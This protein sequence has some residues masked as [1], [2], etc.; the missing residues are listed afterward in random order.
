[1]QEIENFWIAN[2]AGKKT[3]RIRR[4]MHR[5]EVR[6]QLL[7]AYDQ[8]LIDKIRK[9]RDCR[10]SETMNCWHIPDCPDYAAELIF[11]IGTSCRIEEIPG[12]DKNIKFAGAEENSVKVRASL[13]KYSR[14]LRNQR[15]SENTIQ[16]YLTSVK[17]FLEFNRHKDPAMISNEDINRF[18]DRYIIKGSR[19]VSSQNIYISAIKLFYQVIYN[20]EIELEEIERP[21]RYIRLPEI[22]S[23]EEVKRII[24]AMNNIKH[25]TML[26]TVYSCGLR[27]GD[28]LRLKPEDIDSDRMIIHIKHGKGNKDRIVPLSRKLL[29]MIRVYQKVCKTENYLFE[30]MRRGQPY[31]E[32]SLRQVFKTAV[33]RAGI[34]RYAKLHWLRHSYATHLL[35]SGT[36]IRYIQEILGHKSSRTTEIY[37]HVSA[38]SLQKIRNPFDDLEL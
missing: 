10:W 26:A 24:E 34:K 17:N 35:E 19:S 28:L 13:I 21:R 14:Y 22:F 4:C 37:T 7:F 29:E 15:Y 30:G 2:T 1:M 9:L 3:I 23:K 38:S 16:N 8:K 25:K 6:I 31:C 18:N 12:Y 5:Q 36:N 32:T 20:K 27:C 11:K 33:R